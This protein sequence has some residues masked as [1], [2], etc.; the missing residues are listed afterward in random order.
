MAKILVVEDNQDYQELLQNFLEN[1]HHEITAAADG[2]AALA[3]IDSKFYDLI[4]LDLMLPGMDGFDVC[5]AIRQKCDT[6]VII[7][8]AL[9]SESHQMRGYELQIDDYIT[10]PV[11]MALL[12]HKVEAVLRRTMPSVSLSTS[13]TLNYEGISLDLRTHTVCVADKQI[14]FTL[15]EFEILQELM[16]TPGNV[17]TRKSLIEKLWGYDFYDDTRIVDTHMKNIRRKLGTADCIE[18][19]R[20]VGYKLKNRG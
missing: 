17:V 19:V 11:S 8:T 12:L 7:L 4:L 5:R 15:R 9:D 14:D 2:A 1:A 18:T 13:E 16:Q 20:G 10:K 6:P 3:M